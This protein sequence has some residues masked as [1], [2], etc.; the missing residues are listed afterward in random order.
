MRIGYFITHF[1]NKKDDCNHE[2]GGAEFSTHQIVEGMAKRGHDVSVFTTATDA[3]DH[4]GK[5]DGFTV[6]RY[7][8][9][10]KIRSSR[11]SIGLLRGPLRHKLDI[12]HA[13]FTVPSAIAAAFLYSRKKRTPLVITHRSDLDSQFF[14]NPIYKGGILLSNFLYKKVLQQANYIICTAESFANSSPV[15]KDFQDKITIIP[16]GINLKP[17]NNLPAK[18]EC[19]NKL[20]LPLNANVILF[21]GYLANYK[22]PDILLRAMPM[23]LKDKSRVQLVFVGEGPFKSNLESFAEAL[24]ISS[25]VTFAGLID[26]DLKKAF[27]YKSA[28]VFVLPSLSESFGNVILEAMACGVPVVASKVGGIPDIVKHGKNG[29]LVPPKDPEALADAIIYLLENED[30]REKMGKKGQEM[31]KDYSWEKVAEETEEVYEMV[32]K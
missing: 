2:C 12:V 21:V 30:I 27:Y 14:V 9:Q 26:D 17:F 3:K 28:D 16:N 15:L 10:L 7:R 5:L 31:V 32:L 24:N 1:P 8:T 29:L 6:Y 20:G 22:G 23:I 25:N 4:I 19:C 11:F 18:A 13:Q